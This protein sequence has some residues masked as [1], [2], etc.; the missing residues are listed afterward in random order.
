MA[1]GEVSPRESL[2]GRARSRVREPDQQLCPVVTVPHSYGAAG[3]SSSPC[4]HHLCLFLP[5]PKPGNETTVSLL[6][7]ES[8]AALALLVSQVPQAAQASL[9]FLERWLIHRLW[10]IFSSLCPPTLTSGPKS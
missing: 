7:G 1:L 8:P 5:S 2:S 4:R 10:Q 6:T 3:G 9:F